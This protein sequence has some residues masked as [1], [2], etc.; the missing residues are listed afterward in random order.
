MAQSQEQYVTT[1]RVEHDRTR[2]EANTQF[3]GR[4]TLSPEQAEALLACGAIRRPDAP[5]QPAPTVLVGDEEKPDGD[6]NRAA[7]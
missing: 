4:A 3:P 2:Y 1:R 6:A 7:R 5:P